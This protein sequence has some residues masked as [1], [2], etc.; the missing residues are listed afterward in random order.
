VLV[1]LEESLDADHEKTEGPNEPD[2]V[3]KFDI[4]PGIRLGG[5]KQNR[6]G[7]LIC[8]RHAAPVVLCYHR[9]IMRDSYT[10]RF[11]C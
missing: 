6:R 4:T 2:D 3:I 1:L 10:A 11:R 5:K 9:G 7:V 8:L